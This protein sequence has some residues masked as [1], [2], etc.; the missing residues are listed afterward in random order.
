MSRQKKHPFDLEQNFSKIWERIK[1]ASNI[2]NL[3]QLSKIVCS[4][5]QY[6]SR[7]KKENKFPTRWAFIVA[8]KYNLSTDWI[9][10][11]KGR[12][13]LNED[14]NYKSEEKIIELLDEWLK[15]ISK[16]EPDKKI[17]FR[18]Q[19]ESAFPDF[20]EWL[21]RKEEKKECKNNSNKKV[22]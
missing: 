17:W 20:R 18:Y 4:T 7:K 9:M 3:T 10:T 12:K 8:Q 11:G 21:K 1:N 16:N 19:I 22:V 15:T 6:V 5:Q 13:K 2:E 14:I